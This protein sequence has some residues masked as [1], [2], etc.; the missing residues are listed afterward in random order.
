MLYAATYGRAAW[1]LALGPGARITGPDS[2]QDGQ[3]AVYDGSQSRA[4][5][6]AKLTYAWTLPDG[7]HASGP[8][9]T[10]AA[11]GTGAKTLT[12]KVTA[13]DGRS[14]TTTKSI[15]VTAAGGGGGGGQPAGFRLIRLTTPVVH[16]KHNRRFQF[17]LACPVENTLGC[18]GS[19]KVTAKIGKKTRTLGVRDAVDRR[20]VAPCSC[21][22]G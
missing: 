4:F 7:S 21:G 8:S 3:S 19:V 12:L 20:A 17:R 22:C 6:N 18:A 5:N 2:L 13:P 9:V 15:N 16:L 10:Y 14:A 1:R 11:H